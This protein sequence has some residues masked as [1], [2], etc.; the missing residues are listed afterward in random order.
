M[1][2]AIGFDGRTLLVYRECPNK[3]SF[4]VSLGADIIIT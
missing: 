4:A 3:F 1:I 2:G